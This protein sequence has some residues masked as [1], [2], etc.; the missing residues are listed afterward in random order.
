MNQIESNRKLSITEILS[1]AKNA[2]APILSQVVI[3]GEVSNLSSSK[4]GHFYFT[5]S[6]RSSSLS[7]A[8]FKMDAYRSKHITKLKNGDKIECFGGLDIYLMRGSLQFIVKKISP[9]GAGDLKLQF[10]QLKK[11][12]SKEGLFDLDLKKEIPLYPKKIGIVT[13]IGSAAYHD[14]ENI[15]KRRSLWMDIIASNALVQG[16]T[17][18]ASIRKALSKLIAFS[19]QKDQIDVIVI[20]RGGGSM[21]D[22]WCFNDEALAW[23]IYN[24]PIP[25]VSAVGHQVDYTIC[26]FVADLRVETPSAASELLSQ[27]QYDVKTT[28]NYSKNT[29]LSCMSNFENSLKNKLAAFGPAQLLEILNKKI[30][31]LDKRLG[32]LNLLDKSHE[33]FK[34]YEYERRLDDANRDLLVLMEDKIKGLS[35][36][37]EKLNDVAKALDPSNILSRGYSF[38]VDD[39]A[40]VVDSFSSFEKLSNNSILNLTFY[41]GL[42]KVSKV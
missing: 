33:I 11:K 3:I 12:L 17:A 15:F 16:N 32:Q 2:I 30:T 31:Q 20:M 22:L 36:N 23:D 39:N 21:E 13:A 7:C 27:A 9:I 38:V 8:F 35:R 34:I 14:F 26:D 5:L 1:M 24:C 40:Q 6:D 42:G 41:D 10:D 37:L 25:I 29:L 18:P 19:M 28:L 4:T